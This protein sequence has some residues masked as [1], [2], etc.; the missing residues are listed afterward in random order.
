[1]KRAFRFLI[2]GVIMVLSTGL[3]SG[4][5]TYN[6][7][8][9]GFFGENNGKDTI[10]IALYE[11]LSGAYSDEAKAEIMGIELAHKLFP[12]VLDKKVELVY[13]DNGSDLNTD[14]SVLED[15]VEKKPVLVLGSYGSAF[16]MLAAYSGTADH[17][18]TV[19]GVISIWNWMP[20][21]RGPTR[22]ACT[23]QA[24]L[25]ARIAPPSGRRCTSA[26]CHWK[27]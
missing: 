5:A 18:A 27:A 24:G 21:A 12:T 26:P 25:A 4:C 19:E 22:S 11:P 16:S 7:F 23:G 10:K 1:M 17:S 2:I 6:Y 3:F 8:V 15:L 13:V 20:H 9:E 14:K